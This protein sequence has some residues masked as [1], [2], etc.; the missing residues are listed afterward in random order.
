MLVECKRYKRA[1]ERKVIS[2]LLSKIQSVGANK[3]IVISTSGYQS[4]AVEFAKEHKI[5]L[6]SIIDKEVFF[7]T[8][9]S[10]KPDPIMQRVQL[11]YRNK[12]PK[13]FGFLW[14]YDM[15]FPS[16]MIYPTSEMKD[17]A[18]REVMEEFAD[19]LPND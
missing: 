7:I 13:H 1:V 15:D 18:R 14:D 11:A 10:S 6:I 3:G 16:E 12:L 5:T 19:E 8:N 17:T 9:S 2:E 4:G